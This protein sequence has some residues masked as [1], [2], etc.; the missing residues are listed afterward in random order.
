MSWKRRA[1]ERLHGAWS[2]VNRKRLNRDPAQD[3]VV[4]RL[5]GAVMH[6]IA[7][8]DAA[9]TD[10]ALHD[11]EQCIAHSQEISEDAARANI[12]TRLASRRRQIDEIKSWRRGIPT[13]LRD[14]AASN[15]EIKSVE[16]CL[17][18]LYSLVDHGRR[19]V[20][21]AATG[22]TLDQLVS[23]IEQLCR[24]GRFADT[25]AK[26]AIAAQLIRACED[27]PDDPAMINAELSKLFP[28]SW[29]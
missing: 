20:V 10:A 13:D 8:D 14:L 23:E 28:N 27:P 6:A 4:V 25:R 18:H 17:H 11:L 2:E 26:I 21:P 5:K 3:E 24:D 15:I 9:A 16:D 29:K 22:K 12:A 1:Q 19:K 7:S